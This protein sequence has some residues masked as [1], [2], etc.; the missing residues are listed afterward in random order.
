MNEVHGI[1]G[2]YA[3]KVITRIGTNYD[4][5]KNVKELKFD[6]ASQ[7]LF[8]TTLNLREDFDKKFS[9]RSNDSYYHA[10]RSITAQEGWLNDTVHSPVQLWYITG[11]WLGIKILIAMMTLTWLVRSIN[12]CNHTTPHPPLDFRQ[13]DCLWT[14]IWLVRPRMTPTARAD[15]V[16]VV[17]TWIYFLCVLQCYRWLLPLHLYPLRNS[18]LYHDALIQKH[19]GCLFYLQVFEFVG[20]KY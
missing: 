19:F 12:N 13:F 20:W 9:V 5:S 8:S 11:H 14:W 3:V 2:V 15:L 10:N 4:A 6:I 18:S 7:E 1:C 17:G 16:L